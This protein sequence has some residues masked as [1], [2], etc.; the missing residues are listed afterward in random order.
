MPRKRGE[1][2]FQISQIYRDVR[3]ALTGIEHGDGA[4]C[5]CRSDKRGHVCNGAKDVR[6]VR[7]CDNAGALSYHVSQLF[8]L[9]PAVIA[10]PNPFQGRSRASTQLLPRHQIRMVLCLSYDNFIAWFQGVFSA[11]TPPRPS[12]ALPIAVAT[13]LIA[14]VALRVKTISSIWAPTNSATATRAASKASVASSA[15]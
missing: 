11:P 1:I 15:N 10:D 13:M 7:K 4:N 14:S 9:E 6:G 3:G 5:F 12:D 8:S 2:H